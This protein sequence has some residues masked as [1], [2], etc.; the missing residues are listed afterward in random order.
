M[1]R[2]ALLVGGDDSVHALDA[3]QARHMGGQVGTLARNAGGSV[4][5]TT[6]RRT[7]TDAARALVDALG[8]VTV[9]SYHWSRAHTAD[10]NPYFGYLALADIL[11]VSGESASMLA[12]ATATGKPVLIYP[13]GKR[14]KDTH[15]VKFLLGQGVSDW[16]MR[17]AFARP[18]NRRGLERPQTGI[19]LFCAKLAAG[20]WVRPHGDITKLHDALIKRGVARYFDG[21]LPQ[22]T[23][24]PMNE[25]T[26]VAERVRS[27]IGPIDG[28]TAPWRRTATTAGRWTATRHGARAFGGH[29]H[30]AYNTRT[31]TQRPDPIFFRS[32]LTS[33]A[34]PRR[35][36][37]GV[38]SPA[39]DAGR[40]AR[41]D[42]AADTR[43]IVN[44]FAARPLSTIACR[45]GRHGARVWIAW[46]VTEKS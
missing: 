13:L 15:R 20:G 29:E 44:Y 41:C 3:E 42:A 46:C 36:K 43:V 25:A 6:S 33:P 26:K 45:G 10:E 40:A 2:I 17:R 7:D 37:S 8:N 35:C 5:V 28:L 16:I 18:V 21:D 9:H 38:P 32:C 12:E 34:S 22:G 11:I 23:A 27:L 24:A 19:E 31:L 30:S 14:G 4:F 1:P 39:R